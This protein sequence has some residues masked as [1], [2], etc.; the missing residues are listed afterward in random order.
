MRLPHGGHD[1]VQLPSEKVLLATHAKVTPDSVAAVRTFN[2]RYDPI[3]ESKSYRKAK[4]D[5]DRE[6]A[7]RDQ[8]GPIDKRYGDKEPLSANAAI[9]RRECERYIRTK[10]VATYSKEQGKFVPSS[11]AAYTDNADM[12]SMV[13][14]V[15]RV[16]GETRFLFHL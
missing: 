5:E 2:A 15:E 11:M 8:L 12:R 9:V 3:R 6:K 10:M 1:V 16:S 14:E 13:I 4:T 7:F